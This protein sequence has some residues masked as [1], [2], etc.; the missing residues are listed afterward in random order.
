MT[1]AI[2]LICLALIAMMTGCTSFEFQLS[3]SEGLRL[4]I[5]GAPPTMYKIGGYD[6]QSED[7]KAFDLFHFEATPVGTGTVLRAEEDPE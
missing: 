3:Q 1:N 5:E 2:K 7:V 6:R 4:K